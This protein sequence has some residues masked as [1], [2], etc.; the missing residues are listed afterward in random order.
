VK[1]KWKILITI[2]ALVLAGIGIYASTVYANRG[3]VTVQTALVE[4]Q[5]LT[6]LVTASGE[7][8]PKNYIN[9]GANAI[10][11]LTEVAVKEGDHVKK[12]QL[13]ARI[14]N[15]QPAADVQAQQASLSAVEADSAAAEAALKAADDNINTAQADIDRNKPTWRA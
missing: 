14:E 8:K 9:I 7:I 6:S 5:D 2:A 4:R 1:P 11:Q 3:V 10:G 13:L 15:V 12:G